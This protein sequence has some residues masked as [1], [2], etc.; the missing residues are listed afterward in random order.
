MSCASHRLDGG[1]NVELSI[2]DSQ[3]NVIDTM[4]K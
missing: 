3:G 4:G 2:Y 1:I